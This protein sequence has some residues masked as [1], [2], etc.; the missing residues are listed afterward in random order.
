[1][2]ILVLLLLLAACS[3]PNRPADG[4]YVSPGEFV[5]WNLVELHVDQASRE[6]GAPWRVS[7]RIIN[8]SGLDIETRI[9]CALDEQPPVGSVE[10]VA[11]DGK[12]VRWSLSIPTA[13]DGIVSCGMAELD[14]A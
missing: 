4:A 13:R 5:E 8:G 14:D 9:D 6:D 12:T 11:A 3:E 1:M 10:I 2:R 7:G